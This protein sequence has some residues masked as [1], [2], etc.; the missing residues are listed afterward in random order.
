[1][2]DIAIEV[3]HVWKKFR[4]GET[5][6]SLRDLVPAL[7]RRVMGRGPKRTHLGEGE[8]WALEDITFHLKHGEI[9]GIIGPNG[10][11][12]S[13]IL[14]VLSRI[15]RPTRGGVRVNGRLSALI[16]IAAGFHPDLTG[17]ENIYLNGTILGMKKVEIE[18]KFDEIVAFAELEKFLDTPVKRYSSG[19]YVRLAFAVAAHLEPE[20]LLV[21]EV[22]AV[23]DARFQKKCLNKM[24][25]V[26]Q[27]GR[28][29]VFVSHN[30]AAITR[31]CERAILLDHGRAIED[32][33][34][35]QVVRRYLTSSLGTTAAREW[36]DPT[37]APGGEVACLHAVRI[38]TEE[39]QIAEAVD[40]RR[41]IVVEM[42]YDVLKS[43]CV[44]MPHH[45]V[46]NE[47]GI[48][49]FSA[50]DLDPAWACRPRPK[51]RWVSAVRIPGNLLNEGTHFVSSGLISVDPVI[52]QFYQ[53]DAVAFQVVE[54]Q[55]GDSTRGGW[56]GPMGGAVRPLLEWRTEFTPNGPEVVAKPTIVA[57]R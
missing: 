35:Q 17:R 8:F 15:L 20:I 53:R 46:H 6:D 2:S 37:T 47:Q 32:G 10:A 9:L 12:K 18:R 1:M 51:G 52:P 4:R 31:L 23:G 41:P 22:L 26:G 3:S 39:G 11:G 57:R 55:D 40:I 33:P 29:V 30:M 5:H 16:E 19:M 34:A 27:Q 44:L 13:T 43:G 42:E 38:R 49:L 28:T 36:A 45:H 14:K 50:H 54:A 25:D 48:F 24:Q 56:A 7:V 21:D